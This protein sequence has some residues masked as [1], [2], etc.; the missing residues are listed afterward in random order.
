MQKQLAQRADARA[1]TREPVAEGLEHRLQREQ[2]FLP[3]VDEQDRRLVA[4]P[5]TT[6]PGRSAFNLAGRLA[7]TCTATR[8]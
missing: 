4:H 5:E 3:V 6:F 8:A 7:P 2:V 1:R